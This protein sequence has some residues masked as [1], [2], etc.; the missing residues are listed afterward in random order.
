MMPVVTQAKPMGAEG[1]QGQL[2][3]APAMRGVATSRSLP[4]YLISGVLSFA[5]DAGLL[6]VAHGVLGIWLPIAT[7]FAYAVAFGVNFSLNRLWAF[8]SKAPVGRQLIRYVVLAG[9]N[10]VTTI[11][12]VTGLA[13]AGLNYLLA[14]VVAASLIAAINYVAYRVWVFR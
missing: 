10:T 5:V 4:R 2:A 11:L 3:S 8:G 1:S 9:L 7:A 6:Y 13:A 14:K 12:I